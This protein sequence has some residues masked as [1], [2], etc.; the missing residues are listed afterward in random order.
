M[1]AVPVLLALAATPFLAGVCQVRPGSNCYNGQSDGHRSAQGW[2][3]AHGGQ[4]ALQL[5][6]P[7]P[8]PP[9]AGT[10]EI[11]GMVFDRGVT[12]F[13]GLPNWM[14]ELSGTVSATAVTD[15]AGAYSFTG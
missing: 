15:A 11:H 5:P 3:H 9:P 7:P 1:R 13:P 2:A 4:C 8:P 14:V 12:G 10:V 6:P